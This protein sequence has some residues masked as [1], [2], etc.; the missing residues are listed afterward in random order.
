MFILDPPYISKELKEYIIE[1]KTP[2]LV[3][4]T[5]KE[6]FND[7]ELDLI[8]KEEFLNL[9]KKGENIYTC[10]ENS[11]DWIITNIP[12]INMKNNIELMKNK[13]LFRLKIKPMYDN[14]FFKQSNIENLS[15]LNTGDFSYPFI[16]KPNVGFFSIGVYSILN[17]E[18]W[19]KAIDD[20]EEKS[21]LWKKDYPKSVIDTE[22]IL[23]QYIYGEEFAIDAYYDKNGK[24]VI[25]NI[26]KH[27]F[28]GI[29][30]VS[31]RL[32]YTGK[33]IVE[34]Y[35][36]KFTN[37]LNEINSYLN[38]KNFPFHA[39]I[40]I[41]D[42]NIIP[43]E[44]N[45]M[46]F[47]GWSCTDISNFAF[48]FSTYDYYLRGIKPNWTKILEES[49][50]NYYAIVV[51]N[52]SENTKIVDK[53]NY[54]KACNDLGNILSL[55]KIDYNNNS[56]FGFLFTQLDFEDKDTM[57]NILTRNFNDYINI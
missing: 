1:S 36:D 38:I 30:D 16:L 24:A 21:Y 13:S 52:K 56:I 17:E 6:I 2:V 18:D 23:E 29:D 42:D 37:W 33:K 20:I 25:L 4:E 28:N 48:N 27:D 46:R 14:F 3:N 35:L 11:L 15:N 19:Y 26:L 7:N 5:S 22:F 57:N 41:K 43:I 51:L 32:Y 31:D 54:D 8:S 9:Y 39:E 44:F 40:R 34:E 49:N 55:R 45:P 53:F 10:S 12:D 50:Y 47:A